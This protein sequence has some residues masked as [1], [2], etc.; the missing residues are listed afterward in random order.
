MRRGSAGRAVAAL[1]PVAFLGL[2]LFYPLAKVFVLGL[3]PLAAEGWHGLAATARDLGL[4]GL[5]ASS[6]LQAFTSTM[7]SLAIGV[8]AAWVFARC[9]FPGRRLLAVVMAVPFVLPAVSWR[10]HSPPSG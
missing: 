10:R 1:L 7:I 3:A 6:A 5:L 2:F 4:G 9:E 8:P